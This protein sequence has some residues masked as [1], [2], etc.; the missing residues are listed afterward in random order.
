MAETS[1]H[2]PEHSFTTSQETSHGKLWLTAYTGEDAELWCTLQ[3]PDMDEE[4][5]IA[6]ITSD[7]TLSLWPHSSLSDPFILEQVNRFLEKFALP[8][9]LMIEERGAGYVVNTTCGSVDEPLPCVVSI[10]ELINPIN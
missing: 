3:P 1:T 10:R 6:L 4:T 7:N 9:D 2:V 8:L 5:N